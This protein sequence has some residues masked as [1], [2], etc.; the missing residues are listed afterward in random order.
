[1]TRNLSLHSTCPTSAFRCVCVVLSSSVVLFFLFL[2]LSLSRNPIFK[3]IL[4]HF[5]FLSSQL[6]TTITNASSLI[7]KNNNLGFLVKIPFLF[8]GILRVKLNLPHPWLPT[9]R[10]PLSSNRSMVKFVTSSVPSRMH[11]HHSL[12]LFFILILFIVSMLLQIHSKNLLFG[13]LLCAR[14][15]DYCWHWRITLSNQILVNY[16]VFFF[17]EKLSIIE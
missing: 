8:A 16:W 15:R 7:N 6:T 12:F 3:H 4:L 17:I 11:L 2:F 14:D 9:W 13:M 10:W 5:Q 1:M